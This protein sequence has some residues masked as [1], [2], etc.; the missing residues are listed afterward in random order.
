MT[1]YTSTYHVIQNATPLVKKVDEHLANSCV[2]AKFT[3][4]VCFGK[5]FSVRE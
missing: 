2:H 3:Q 5:Q 4:S 1:S